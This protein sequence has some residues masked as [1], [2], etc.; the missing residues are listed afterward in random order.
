MANFNIPY[1]TER[2]GQI[3]F[4]DYENYKRRNLSKHVKEF[5]SF[6]MQR[7]QNSLCSL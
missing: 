2:E 3:E 6:S 7:L 5:H 4:K 1:K